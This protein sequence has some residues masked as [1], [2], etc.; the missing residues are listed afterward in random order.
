M[1]RANLFNRE[2]KANKSPRNAF[3]LGYS[4]LFSTPVGLLLP[5]YVQEVKAGDKM[6]LNLSNVTRTRPLNT[7]A[8]MAFDEKIDFWYVPTYL[9]WSAYDEWRLAQNFPH[10]TAQLQNAG[11]QNL[12]P[13]TSYASLV[14]FLNGFSGAVSSAD[15]YYTGAHVLRMLDLCLYG[16][17]NAQDISNFTGDFSQDATNPNSQL[18]GSIMTFYTMLGENNIPIN[19]FRLAAFQCVYMCHYRNEEYEKQD[20][21]YYNLDSLFLQESSNN[22]DTSAPSNGISSASWLTSDNGGTGSTPPA[23]SQYL[24]SWKKLMTPRFKN[25][26]KDVFTSAKP[27]SG[28]N[29][30]I[31]GIQQPSSYY[32][33][34]FTWPLSASVDIGTSGSSPSVTTGSPYIPSSPSSLSNN[35]GYEYL[36]GTSP[37]SRALTFETL[38]GTVSSSGVASVSLYPQQIYN[39]IAQDKF[40]RSSVYANK[41]LADQYK[42]LFGDDYEDTHCPSYL[43]SFS[44]TVNISDVTATAAGNDGDTDNLS[45]SLLGEIAGKGYNTSG[46]DGVFSRNF[47]YDGI[48]IGVHYIMP[49]NNYD[50]GR[51]SKFNTKLS[52]YDYFYP[53]FD[54]LGLQPVYMFERNFTASSRNGMAVNSLFGYAPRFYE[55]KQRTNEV[56]NGFQSNQSDRDWTLANNGYDAVTAA[57]FWNYK[58]KPDITDRIFTVAWNTAPATD[59]FQ[60]YFSYDVTLVSNMEIYGTPS[61]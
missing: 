51:I 26:R 20:P 21:S 55:Y 42:A 53:A 38:S 35:K 49:R 9:L 19:Y 52:R 46:K 59:P 23:R 30:A 37:S 13:F 47:D 45:S 3:D 8:F 39:L 15:P 18:A 1:A 31:S 29:S 16:A 57:D 2:V 25:W 40:L 12:C 5:A 10:S 27:N 11:T 33:S 56:H 22:I 54:G 14:A 34:S 4:T 60:C 43:G 50:S 7:S 32:G 24:P 58:I 48:V 36:F 44:T 6:K 41:N 61:I 28:F 17:Y